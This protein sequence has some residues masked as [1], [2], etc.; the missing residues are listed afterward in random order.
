VVL[1][2][3]LLGK[4]GKHWD[5]VPIPNVT[6]AYLKPETFDFSANAA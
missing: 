2:K 5:S 3:F 6:V 1:D 4:Q